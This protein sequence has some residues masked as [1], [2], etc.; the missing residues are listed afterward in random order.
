MCGIV[1]FIDGTKDKR[2]VIK[3]MTDKISHR[4]P[5][6]EG[7]YI[8]DTIALGHRRLS[9]IDIDNGKQP[10]FSKDN[11][12]VVVFN[13]E[14]YNYRELKRELENLGY[15]FLEPIAIQRYYYMDMKNGKKNYQRD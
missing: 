4:G 6:G 14:I 5:D 7:Y 9:I 13:G 12:L 15:D 10:M 11:N 2:I 8:D 3:R 1:G